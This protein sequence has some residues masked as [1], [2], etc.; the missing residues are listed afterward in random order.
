MQQIV[1]SLGPSARKKGLDLRCE[2]ENGAATPFRGDPI[3]LRQVLVNLVGNA[4]KFTERGECVVSVRLLEHSGA[5]ALL[6]FAVRD[7]GIG[8]PG[9]LHDVI[10]ERFAQADA[11]ITRKYGGTG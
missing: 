9:E 2:I 6:Q 4:I 3:R 11:S 1:W 5:T 10:F 7:T 8:V